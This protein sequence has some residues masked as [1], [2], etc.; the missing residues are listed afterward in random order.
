MPVTSHQHHFEDISYEGAL[1]NSQYYTSWAAG[2]LDLFNTGANKELNA[3]HKLVNI[4]VKTLYATW[5][6]IKTSVMSPGVSCFTVN[7]R[8]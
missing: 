4:S 1:E 8:S 6:S 5:L 2:M 7:H 3:Y